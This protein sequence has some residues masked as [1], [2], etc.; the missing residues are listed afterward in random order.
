MKEAGSLA[1]KADKLEA[2]RGS[3]SLS[4]CPWR[5]WAQVVQSTV[6]G[7]DGTKWGLSRNPQP[8][9]GLSPLL[10]ASLP[11]PFPHASLAFD[12]LITASL[13][14]SFGSCRVNE[15]SGQQGPHA[16]LLG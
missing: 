13:V 14:G 2:P 6:H 11:L 1:L 10:P 4:C 9:P 3:P 5:L 15:F 12:L 16:L 7:P 8:E